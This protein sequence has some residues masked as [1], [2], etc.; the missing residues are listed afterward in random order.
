MDNKL[1]RVANYTLALDT[2]IDILRVLLAIAVL[3]CGQLLPEPRMILWGI[4][5]NTFVFL[6][7]I[8]FV[9]GSPAKP[10]VVFDIIFLFMPIL[11]MGISLCWSGN[12]E[13]G[14]HKFGNLF[15]SSFLVVYLMLQV[16]GRR[17]LDWIFRVWL[18]VMAGLLC[19][20]FIYKVHFGFFHREVLFFLNGPIVFARFMGGAAVISLLVL[21]GTKKWVFYLIFSLAV[22]WTYS[23][24]PLLSLIVVTLLYC[25]RKKGILSLFFLLIFMLIFSY[26]V[27]NDNPIIKGKLANNRY[28]TAVLSVAGSGESSNNFGSIGIR[29]YMYKQSIDMIKTFPFG[30]GLGGWGKKVDDSLGLKYPHNFFLE[31]ISECGWIIGFV[32]VIPFIVFLSQWR[33]SYSLVPLFFLFAQQFSGDLLDARYLLS[34]SVVVFLYSFSPLRFS[35]EETADSSC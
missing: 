7:A 20:A 31:I 16:A 2:G 35:G 1:C 10:L 12:F 5:M 33:S 25:Y 13:Y 8:F 4:P 6:F 14:L 9:F 26:A 23:K 28:G 30:V 19:M 3:F 32:S 29:R 27:L 18:T 11:F 17:T 15:L 21:T 24:G 22:V 34:F